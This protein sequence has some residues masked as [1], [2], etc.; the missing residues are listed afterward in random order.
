MRNALH[1][2][3]DTG[4][5]KFVYVYSS[6]SYSGTQKL[7]GLHQGIAELGLPQDA[8]RTVHGHRRFDEMA[9]LLK[10]AYEE[11]A[12]DAILGSSDT[13]GVGAVKFAR[14]MG[15][16]IPE[17]LQIVSWNDSTLAV[18]SS[19]ELTSVDAMLKELC[20]KTC[21]HLMT[22]LNPAEDAQGEPLE[23]EIPKKTVIAT[24]LVTRET[25][26]F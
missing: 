6:V 22:L 1:Q 18:A 9:Q 8:L 20:Q 5:R 15:L 17:D 4:A 10:E 19:P 23:T 16:R 24:R 7:A 26:R 3:Y 2:L 21:Q 14:R 13:S 11:E 25:T 12:F